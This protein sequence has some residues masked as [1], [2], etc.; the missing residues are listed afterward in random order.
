MEYFP[1]D[2]R[3]FH[4]TASNVIRRDGI[5]DLLRAGFVIVDIIARQPKQ[6]S[7]SDKHCVCVC[8]FKGH[9]MIISKRIM[10]A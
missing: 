3:S 8:V 1:K 7:D 9:V 6:A 10:N 2:S 4:R 5:V